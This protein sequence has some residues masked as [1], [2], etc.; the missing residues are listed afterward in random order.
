MC[1]LCR[2]R[3]GVGW[4]CAGV[5]CVQVWGGCGGQ[6]DVCRCVVGVCGGCV[7]VWCGYGVRGC[8]VGAGVGAGDGCVHSTD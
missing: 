5:G 4:V 8:G 1:G 7:Q 2:C 6:V 3:V